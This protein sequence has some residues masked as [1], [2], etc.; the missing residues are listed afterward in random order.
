MSFVVKK[1]GLNEFFT[2]DTVITLDPSWDDS[3][4]YYNGPYP[5]QGVRYHDYAVC[6]WP[7]KDGYARFLGKNGNWGYIHEITLEPFWLDTSVMYAE[8]SCCGL[9]RIQYADGTY[10]YLNR[11]L[12]CL[13]KEYF[14]KASIFKDGY[15]I[16]SDDICNDYQIDVNG[17]VTDRDKERYNEAYEE[18]LEEKRQI[19]EEQQNRREKTRY[20]VY[21][22]ESE[23]MSALSGCGGNPEDFGF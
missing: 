18:V 15:A 23:V 3:V 20:S 9:A 14:I 21:D 7:I 8:D 16:V 5:A 19:E 12:K 22:P 13:S 1:N 2:L 6:I 10:N 4:L 17:N 11:S